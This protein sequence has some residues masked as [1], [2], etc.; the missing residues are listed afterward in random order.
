MKATKRSKRH[1]DKS[2]AKIEF[3]VGDRVLLNTKNLKF[4]GLECRKLMPR[5]I[6]PFP[7]EE[8]VGNVSYKLTLPV[9]MSVHPIFH[10]ELLR[11]FRGSGVQPSPQIE[12]EDGTVYWSLESIVAV[13][14]K[15]DKRRYRVRWVGFG[16]EHDTWEPRKKLIE[17]AP[18]VVE[19]FVKLL[20]MTRVGTQTSFKT[21]PRSHSLRLAAVSL[22]DI[23][24]GLMAGDRGLDEPYPS[25]SRNNLTLT[26]SG[27]LVTP[28]RGSWG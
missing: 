9:T 8:K 5:F 6:G 3:E 16:P 27:P 19:E 28:P 2:P 18:E 4:K 21:L 10:V 24:V 26:F 15:G 1:F 23:R 11:P 12:C 20:S 25:S 22:I 14:G 13:R 7:I 17:D